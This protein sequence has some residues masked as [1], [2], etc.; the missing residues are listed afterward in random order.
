MY[1]V[2]LIFGQNSL[3][4]R[5]ILPEIWGAVF[6]YGIRNIENRNSGIPVCQLICLTKTHLRWYTF[7]CGLMH[8]FLTIPN[9]VCT[10]SNL[11]SFNFKGMLPL[12]RA[13]PYSMWT[14]HD[15][16]VI[17]LSR[18]IAPDQYLRSL[19]ALRMTWQSFWSCVGDIVPRWWIQPPKSQG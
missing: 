2:S 5:I 16:Y 13:D 12:G 18:W 1:P 4:L 15:P 3:Y 9:V 14:F 11:W 6:G 7:Q 17:E 10:R 8:G 19:T